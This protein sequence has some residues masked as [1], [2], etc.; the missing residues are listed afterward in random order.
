MA[1]TQT[2]EKY[3]VEDQDIEFGS[4][5]ETREQWPVIPDETYYAKAYAWNTVKKA[6]YKQEAQLAEL[7]KKHPDATLADIDEWQWEC[8]FRV[9]RGEHEGFELPYRFNRTTTWH[10]KATATIV[11]AALAQLSKYDAETLRARFGSVKG[12]IASQPEVRIVVTLMQSERDKM[13]RNY[14]KDVKPLPAAPA[15]LFKKKPGMNQAQATLADEKRYREAKPA[16]GRVNLLGF[17]DEDEV[18]DFPSGPG[19]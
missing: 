19:E 11:V 10:E 1:D 18:P 17:P 7:R 6:D 16:V 3:S 9:T 2:V 5:D 12:L 4:Y 14:V 15:D 13:W 8:W